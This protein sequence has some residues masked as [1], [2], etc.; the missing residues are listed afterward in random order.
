M[1][2]PSWGHHLGEV[3]ETCVWGGCC[4]YY[5]CSL[6]NVVSSEPHLR[7]QVPTGGHCEHLVLSTSSGLL[8]PLHHDVNCS[9]PLCPLV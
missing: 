8:H 4:V 7:E 2:R 3:L 1:L 5:P 9:A 6:W